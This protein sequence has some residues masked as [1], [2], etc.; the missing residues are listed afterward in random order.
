MCCVL[1]HR[2]LV[3]TSAVLTYQETIREVDHVLTT[4]DKSIICHAMQSTHI[5][6][7]YIHLQK[8]III[9]KMQVHV[10]FLLKLHTRTFKSH[11]YSCSVVLISGD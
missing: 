2:I 1:C 9:F 4:C 11:Y 3:L 10:Y 5:L 7:F 6:I 8:E